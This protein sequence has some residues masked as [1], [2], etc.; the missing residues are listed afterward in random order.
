MKFLKTILLMLICSTTFASTVEVSPSNFESVIAQTL[1]DTTEDSITFD[2]KQGEY[3]CTGST[4][5][6]A[7]NT[8][9][10]FQSQGFVTI[11]HHGLSGFHNG[12]PKSN[13]ACFFVLTKSFEL[14]GFTFD[15]NYNTWLQFGNFVKLRCPRWLADDTIPISK[16]QPYLAGK[17]NREVETQLEY[18]SISNVRVIDSGDFT[19]EKYK[20]LNHAS[21]RLGD[22]W[23][24]VFNHVGRIGP[25]KL[26]NIEVFC[27]NTEASGGVGNTSELWWSSCS[28]YG[29]GRTTGSY[30][31]GLSRLSEDITIDLLVVEDCYAADAY[32]YMSIIGGD[33]QHDNTVNFKRIVYR[34]NTMV[35]SRDPVKTIGFL[36]IKNN[37]GGVLDFYNNTFVMS[38]NL[39]QN[40]RPRM[41]LN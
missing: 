20:S 23:F 29:N 14:D 15:F 31:G 27:D 5:L 3:Q 40:V 6:F 22:R 9:V 1:E 7:P 4:I 19:K 36:R 16:L 21:G 25:I 34:D 10:K 37:N 41:V 35:L 26:K 2:F 33:G 30:F 28:I 18:V 32:R 24:A 13:Q 39:S 38:R 11:T 8:H 12:H 17:D